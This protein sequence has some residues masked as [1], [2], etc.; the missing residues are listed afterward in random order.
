LTKESCQKAAHKILVEFTTGFPKDFDILN[1]VT[2]LQIE[3]IREW[4]RAF[5]QY[6][7]GLWLKKIKWDQFD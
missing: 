3:M 4:Y 5:S 6:G 1:D 7:M 2:K